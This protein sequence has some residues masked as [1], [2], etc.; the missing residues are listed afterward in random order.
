MRAQPGLWNGIERGKGIMSH[1]GGLGSPRG[2]ENRYLGQA[3]DLDTLLCNGSLRG[4]SWDSRNYISQDPGQSRAEDLEPMQKVLPTPASS[5]FAHC[6]PELDWVWNWGQLVGWWWWG[7]QVRQW[8]VREARGGRI[9]LEP[10]IQE[11]GR[12][13]SATSTPA[14]LWE[15]SLQNSPRALHLFG[16]LL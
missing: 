16:L 10:Q 9:R 13:C 4:Q 5:L 15:S 12:R 11:C 1:L 6:C 14:L 2:Q 7:G 3:G 8:K